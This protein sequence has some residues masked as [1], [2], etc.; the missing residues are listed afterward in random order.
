M[1]RA[2]H[3]SFCAPVEKRSYGYLKL[4]V[5]L[6]CN[7]IGARAREFAAGKS[8]HHAADASSPS[9]RASEGRLVLRQQAASGR[10]GA[11]RAIEADFCARELEWQLAEGAS[12]R[13]ASRLLPGL[14]ARRSNGHDLHVTNIH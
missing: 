6:D 5:R 1:F 14:G 7:R 11:L 12:P 8:S 13:A 3:L 9:E 4:G 2:A 10:L